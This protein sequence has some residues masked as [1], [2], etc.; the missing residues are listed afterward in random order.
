M[1]FYCIRVKNRKNIYVQDLTIILMADGFNVKSIVFI[2]NIFYE[3]V[4]VQG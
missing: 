4:C 3:I 2:Q 1:Q